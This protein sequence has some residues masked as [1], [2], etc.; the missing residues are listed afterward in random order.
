VAGSPV[1][2]AVFGAQKGAVVGPVQSDFGWVVAKVESVERTGGKSLA[3]ARGEIAEKLGAEKRKHAI[4]ELVNQVQE[5]VDDGSNFAEAA[6]AAKLT[7]LTTPMIMADGRSRTDTGYK[8]PAE[9]AKAVEAGFQIAP[10]DPPEVISLGED[11]GYAMVG[12]AEVVPAAAAPLASI[13]ERV[14]GDWIN[15]QAT[16]RARRAALAIE[17]KVKGGMPLAEA[18]RGADASLPSVRPMA[19][20]RIEIANATGVVSPAM[21]MLF[22]LAQGKAKVVADPQNRGFFVI[23]VDKIVPGN[24]MLQPNLIARMQTELR[25]AVGE[26]YAAQFL[27]AMRKDVEVKRNESAIAATK[28]RIVSGSN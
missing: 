7:V 21:R 13:R 5:A 2:S 24:A 27:A 28:Q 4:E 25:Q 3:E 16:D 17:A 10:N 8:T 1:A 9:L 23:K 19:A 15:S 26:D 11:A 22:T 12:P 20:R 18:V 14:R 6:A